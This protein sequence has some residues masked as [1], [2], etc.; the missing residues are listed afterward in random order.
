MHHGIMQTSGGQ[1]CLTLLDETLNAHGFV[2]IHSRL[3]A[4]PQ[5]KHQGC[6]AIRRPAICRTVDGLDRGQALLL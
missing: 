1:V 3:A 5:A 4:T 6:H 2:Y